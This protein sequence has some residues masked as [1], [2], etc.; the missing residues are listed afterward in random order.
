MPSGNEEFERLKREAMV[1]GNKG[2]NSDLPS[3]FIPN[4]VFAFLGGVIAA[5][6]MFRGFKALLNL[7]K[8]FCFGRGAAGTVDFKKLGKWA[9]VT[10]AT[11]GIGKAYAEELADEGMN[12]FL[13]SRTQS[14]LDEVATEIEKEN[15]GVETKTLAVD[16]SKTDIYDQIRDALKDLDIGVLVNNVGM[17]YTHADDYVMVPEDKHVDILNINC[18]SV[19]RMMSIVMPGMMERKRGAIINISSASGIRPTPLLSSYGATKAFVDSISKA[20]STEVIYSKNPNVI[21]QSVTP[22]FVKT[23][24]AGIKRSSF[25]V[26]EPNYFAQSALN[27]VGVFDHTY[28]CLS[29]ELQGAVVSIVPDFIFR[30]MAY[31]QLHAAKMKFLKKNK[32]SN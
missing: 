20:V 18:M 8:V 15:N 28:G 6:Y 4:T 16:F 31:R 14:K 13:M 22:F 27:T 7:V 19:V 32:K 29:H 3:V 26:P 24:L 10:G 11:D 30:L 25:F 23:K 5:Y 2:A 9:V 17:S 1:S 12:V 21:V